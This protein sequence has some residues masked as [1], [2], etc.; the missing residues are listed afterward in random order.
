[1]KESI[2]NK[3]ISDKKIEL[4]NIA[5]QHSNSSKSKTKPSELNKA[6]KQ[7]S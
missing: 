7:L 4:E 2:V 3:Q 5:D 1:M 6:K